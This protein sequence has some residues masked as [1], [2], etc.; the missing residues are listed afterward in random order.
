MKIV[1][2][3]AVFVISAVLSIVTSVPI[4]IGSYSFNK[5]LNDIKAL[6]IAVELFELDNHRLPTNEEG[7]GIL[8]FKTSGELLEWKQYVKELPVDSWKNPY[9]YKKANN[10]AGFFIYS[11]G[12]NLI[13][14]SG[15]GDD[16]VNSGKEYS[17]E[18]YGD[19]HSDW[20]YV[21]LAA[22]V[23]AAVTLLTIII[24][25]CYYLV[26]LVNRVVKKRRIGR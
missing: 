25:A 16:I 10:E 3:I 1:I 5:P 2:V 9:L 26:R 18:E 24:S 17:C 6:E 12:R 8:F 15:A 11:S 14:E 19:C 7:L 13:P 20:N 22:T 4:Q 23:V 21:Y